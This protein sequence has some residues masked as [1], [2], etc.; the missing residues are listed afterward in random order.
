MNTSLDLPD[1]APLGPL[2]RA[3]AEIAQATGSKVIGT[4]DDRGLRYRLVPMY[5]PNNRTAGTTGK[6]SQQ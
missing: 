2:H 1:S 5:V 3:L 6:E 4:A